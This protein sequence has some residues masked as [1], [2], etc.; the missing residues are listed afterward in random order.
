MEGL[1]V[2]LDVE[3]IVAE[4]KEEKAAAAV[5]GMKRAAECSRE[6][7]ALRARAQNELNERARVAVR[8][9]RAAAACSAS[10]HKSREL[11]NPTERSPTAEGLSPMARSTLSKVSEADD[12]VMAGWHRVEAKSGRCY[13]VN[14]LTQ[15][16]QWEVPTQSAASS[17]RDAGSENGSQPSLAALRWHHAIEA[18]ILSRRQHRMIAQLKNS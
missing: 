13:F 12:G 4:A 10:P 3:A 16:S 8:S 1:R 9:P 11:T 18:L 7:K 15:Q 5:T 14:S 2:Q 6:R 17:V